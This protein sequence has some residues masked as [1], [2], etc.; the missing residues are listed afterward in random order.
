[1]EAERAIAARYGY[2]GGVGDRVSDYYGGIGAYHQL[3]FFLELARDMEELCPGATLIETAN[4]VFEG[5]TLVHRTTGIRVIGVCHGH[6][7]W[8]KLATALGLDLD[9]AWAQVAGFNHC[10][11]LT[12][13]SCQGQDAYPQV[14]EWIR[15]KARKYWRSGEYRDGPAWGVEQLSPAAVDMY[16]TFGLFPIGDTVRSVSPWWHHTDLKTK[17]KW[18][19]PTGGF[20][21]EIGWASYLDLH[22][23]GQQIMEDLAKDPSVPVTTLFPLSPSGEQHIPIIDAMVNDRPVTLQLNIPNRGSI[24]GIGDDVIVEIPAVVGGRGAQGL[25]VGELPKRLMHNIMV[26]RMQRM[27]QILQ[28]FLEGDRQSLMLTL[29]DDRRTRSAEKAQALL[30]EL[31]SQP[32][33]EAAARHY[34]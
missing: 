33:N 29:L 24:R 3:R 26:P 20:D 23:Q 11:W 30:E 8:Q 25:Q 2:P 15:E 6:F 1:M 34:R 31:L 18:F 19:G 28:A 5:T 32:W 22:R 17:K 12:H 9:S 27:E 4:P 10:I 16:R 7:A 13:L 14:D 21:S